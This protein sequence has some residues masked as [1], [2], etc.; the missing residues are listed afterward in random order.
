[1]PPMR[2]TTAT[3]GV[4]ELGAGVKVAGYH[5]GSLVDTAQ[6]VTGGVGT[7][8]GCECHDEKHGELEATAF[9]GVYR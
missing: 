2:P 8:A 7:D 3:D 9:R 6:A 4:N 1:M 5:R